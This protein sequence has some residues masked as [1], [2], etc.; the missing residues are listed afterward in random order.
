MSEMDDVGLRGPRRRDRLTVRLVVVLVLVV[1]LGAVGLRLADS[2]GSDG[3]QAIGREGASGAAESGT[4][5]RAPRLPGE[6]LDTIGVVSYNAW[7]RL[8]LA[9]AERDW[10]RLTAQQRIDLIGWQESKSPAF[11]DLYPRYRAR[12]WETWHH[13]DP[14]GPVSLAF[15]WRRATFELLDVTI[16]RM[17]RGGFPRETDAPF[18]A[19]WVVQ[20][21]L[22]HRPSG[23]TVTLLNTHVNQTIETGQR[24]ERNLNAERAKLHLRRLA[25][26]WN[27]VPGDVVIGT[28]DYNFDHA[29]DAAARP[30]GGIA[31]RFADKAVSSYDALGLRGVVPT[32]NT[33]WIDYVWLST[34]SLRGPGGTGAAGTVQFATHR[35]L[36]GYGS[37]HRP[38][39]ARIRL[40]A[41]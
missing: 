25:R 39:L 5:R 10:D 32:R 2:R 8:P 7:R 26:L 28:G 22:R 4:P 19:R 37:D 9:R 20:A 17:H 23:R 21:E 27:T 29:D 31:R 14:D 12:G 41:G 13:P 33:R 40:Y 30:A 3:S 34:D 16:H 1:S 24:F 15:S 36:G 18:P 38:I 35:S 6:V 11:R